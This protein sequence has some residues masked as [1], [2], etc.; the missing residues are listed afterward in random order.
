MKGK[1]SSVY[2]FAENIKSDRALFFYRG[3]WALYA[4]LKSMGVSQDDQVISAVFTC[5]AVPRSIVRLGA[6]PVYVD[7][8]PT[9]FNIDS[10]KIEEKI[11]AKTKLSP[12]LFT[13]KF[14]T[15]PSI[16]PLVSWHLFYD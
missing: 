13:P 14:E 16:G 5:P 11:T 3:G 12:Y 10:D 2:R 7:I 6:I 1:E 4:L 8:D 15:R 9:S